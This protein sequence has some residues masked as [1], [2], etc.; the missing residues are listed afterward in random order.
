MLSPST[1]TTIA[2]PTAH[3]L[4]AYDEYTVAYQNRGAI[5]DLAHTQHTSHGLAP[6]IIVDG[7]IVGTWKRTIKKDS[8][9]ITT[10]LLT[11][12]TESQNQA[13]ATALERYNKFAKQE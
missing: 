11:P 1:P 12:L 4:P 8:T 13:L 3:L 7:H 5:L 6:T 9:T 10:T 2:S